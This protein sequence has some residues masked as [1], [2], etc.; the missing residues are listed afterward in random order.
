MPEQREKDRAREI[1][2]PLQ[3]HCGEKARH[4]LSDWLLC[5]WPLA[6]EKLPT[7]QNEDDAASAAEFSFWCVGPTSGHKGQGASCVLQ[8]TPCLS[9]FL[10]NGYTMSML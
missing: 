8:L 3:R 7:H 2:S 5:C 4:D 1:G 9:I 10:Y 6:A